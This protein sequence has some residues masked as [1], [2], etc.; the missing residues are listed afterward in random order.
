MPFSVDPDND[1]YLAAVSNWLTRLKLPLCKVT[2]IYAVNCYK[3]IAIKNL[4]R[5][6][7]VSSTLTLEQPSASIDANGHYSSISSE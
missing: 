7:S 1:S 2:V 5:Q 4:N 3:I 6:N